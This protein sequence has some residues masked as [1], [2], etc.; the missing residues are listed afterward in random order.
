VG[1]PSPPT[2]KPSS[3]EFT[4]SYIKVRSFGLGCVILGDPASQTSPR[5]W[6]L[7]VV[8]TVNMSSGLFLVGSGNQAAVEIK[9]RMEMQ[10]EI[11][12]SHQD[13][14]IKN[15][16]AIRAEKRLAIITKRAGSLI[17]GTFNTSP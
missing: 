10:I 17:L 6:G 14:F 2:R 13:F 4:A 15:L 8:P 11:S 7:D 12:N 5:I 3:F 9:D 16:L 1:H